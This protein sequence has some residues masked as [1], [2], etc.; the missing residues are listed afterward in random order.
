M[1]PPEGLIVAGRFEQT[2][3]RAEPTAVALLHV[4]CDFYEPVR[5]SLEAFFPR[6]SPG[7]FVVL[8]D[9]GTF[10]GCRAAT[11][12]FL[13]RQGLVVEPT[14]IDHAAVFLQKP[15]APTSAPLRSGAR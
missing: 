8:N 6:V 5:L 12:E 13:A 14:F 7:G 1:R 11:E 3:G 2:F 15:T 10:P 4:D 9:Y